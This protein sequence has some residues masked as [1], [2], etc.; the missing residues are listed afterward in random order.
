MM[1]FMLFQ[2][3]FSPGMLI[4]PMEQ[5]NV[6]EMDDFEFKTPATAVI[7]QLAIWDPR[8]KGTP[9]DVVPGPPT[10]FGSL[11]YAH[12]PFAS[13]RGP[14]PGLGPAQNAGPPRPVFSAR[15]PLYEP[16]PSAAGALGPSRADRAHGAD[17]VTLD[18]YGSSGAWRGN[19]VFSDGS[20]Q[21]IGPTLST[22]PTDHIFVREKP[23]TGGL[24]QD[25]FMRQ[26]W[27]GVAVNASFDPAF[28]AYAEPDGQHIYVDGD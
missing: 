7:P 3:I 27:R 9:K 28:D 17:S 21:F 13:L 19:V 4:S 22:K 5:A 15:G 10:D 20:V 26:Y 6:H 8:F 16:D 12:A 18:M 14:M 11:S 24:P 23:G 25:A 2:A 1:S